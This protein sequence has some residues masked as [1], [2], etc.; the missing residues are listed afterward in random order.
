MARAV[1]VVVF[2]VELFRNATCPVSV[3]HWTLVAAFWGIYCRFW[4]VPKSVFHPPCLSGCVYFV[5]MIL[6]PYPLSTHHPWRVP[7]VQAQ[8]VQSPLWESGWQ[9]WATPD[10]WQEAGCP[11]SLNSDSCSCRKNCCPFPQL[12]QPML[13][14][15]MRPPSIS[16]PPRPL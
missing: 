15:L 8:L 6:C 13:L 16:P 4:C 1:L 11:V 9:L 3:H 5:P 2:W 7:E 14:H 10:R 12:C